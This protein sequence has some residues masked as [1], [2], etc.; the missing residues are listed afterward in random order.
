MSEV[1][2]DASGDVHVAAPS[3]RFPTHDFGFLP[4]PKRLRYDPERPVEFGLVLNMIFGASSTFIV[5]NLYYSQPLLIHLSES[6]GVSYDRISRVPTLVQ[7][8]YAAGILLV[9]PLGDLVR[10]RQLL[11]LI[12]TISTLLTIGLAAT[13]SLVAFEVLCF[14]IG[15]SSCA[16]QVLVPLAADLAPP[17]RRASAISIVLSG[18]LLGVLFSRVMSGVVAQY[19][20]WR[21]VYAAACGLQ[22]ASLLSLWAT[23]PDFP[24]KAKKGTTY[25]QILTT[26]FKLAATEPTVIQV[27]LVQVAAAAC[28]TQFWVTLTYLLGDNPYHYGSTVIGLFGLIGFVGVCCTPIYGR[29]IDRLVPWHVSVSMTIGL[30]LTFSLYWGA[31]GVTLAAPVLVTLGL[32]VFRQSQQIS[33]ATRIFMLDDGLRSRLNACSMF[34][35]CMGQAIGSAAGSKVFLEYGWRANGALMVAF[36]AFQ[37]FVLLARGPHVGRYTW[38]GYE[39]GLEWRRE[40]PMPVQDAEKSVTEKDEEE[41]SGDRTCAPSLNGDEKVEA[42][43]ED[44]GPLSESQTR[45]PSPTQNIGDENKDVAI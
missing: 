20:T 37:L 25:P 26:M 17:H 35:I 34:S 11:L 13:H 31:A 39:G 2:Q 23:L 1:K 24:P 18:L 4:I 29:A 33:L 32:D 21:V 38:F 22:A 27:C 6:F 12:I 16:P 3:A 28:F 8:G 42:E 40:R 30:L 10:R 9:T 44:K 14:F 43:E 36:C 45:V 5:A 41:K 19:V 15:I 7:G